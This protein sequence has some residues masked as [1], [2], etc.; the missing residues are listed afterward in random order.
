MEYQRDDKPGAGAPVT[1]DEAAGDRRKFLAD[2]GRFSVVTPPVI[3][4]LLSTTLVS[5]AIAHS[6][7][8]EGR[9][10][11]WDE[12]RHKGW[13]HDRDWDDRPRR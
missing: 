3:S 2:L 11:G 10:H 13:D 5:E 6:G 9:H 1:H 4:L 7:G 12:G 8:G